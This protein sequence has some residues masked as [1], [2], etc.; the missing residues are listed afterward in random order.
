MSQTLNKPDPYNGLRR[1]EPT[2][3]STAYHDP[4]AYRRDIEAIWYRN[5]VLVCRSAEIAE[6]LSFR[7]VRIGGQ[8]IVV[9]RD[10]TGTLRAFHNTCRHRG[11]QLC[12][13]S[14]GRLKARLITCPYHAWSYSLRGDLVRVPSKTLP[15]GFDRSDY[16]LYSVALEE[17]RGFVFVNLAETPGAP[18]AESFDRESGDLSNWP[19]E[20]LVAGHV[21]RTALKCNWKVFWENFNECLHCPGVHKHL[22]ALVPIYGRGLMARHDD[23]EWALHA[24]N[25]AAEFSGGL[26]FGAETWSEDGCAHGPLFPGLSERDRAAGQTYVMNLPSMFVVGHVDYVRCVR[27]SPLGPEETELTAEWLFLPEQLAAPGFDI[28]NIVDFG[29]RVLEEDADVCEL[30]QR[31]LRSARHD[32]GVLMPEE[33]DIHRFHNWVRDQHARHDD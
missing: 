10:E 28:A 2:L 9:V 1:A 7:T 26:R 22:S 18:L 32:R 31:G 16:P 33:Y 20:N 15:E 4:E 29:I 14:E 13:E 21:F 6:P 24:D 12:R 19:L 30:N 27:L 11:A 23:P 8:E 25:D 5:W 3:P 17:W